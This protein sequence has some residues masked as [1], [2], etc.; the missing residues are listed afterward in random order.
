LTWTSSLG[1]Q[2]KALSG[3]KKRIGI[4]AGQY[5]DSET[6]LHYNYH[7]YYDPNTGRYLTPDPIGLAGG[8]NLFSYSS[9][10]PAN[11]NDPY[12]LRPL[13]SKEINALKKYFG[14]S[15]KTDKIDLEI[16]S[17]GGAWSPYGNQISLPE[18]FFKNNDECQELELTDPDIFSIF[19]HEAFHV[20]Q[21]QHGMNVTSEAFFLHMVRILSLGNYDPYEYD[22]SITTPVDLLNEFRSSNVEAQAQIYQDYVW[23]DQQNL[24]SGYRRFSTSKFS[25]VFNYVY[26]P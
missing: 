3:A 15:L 5:Y 24:R 12:G 18:D 2:K 25:D 13:K 7:R 1:G 11:W 26:R 21:R 8:L 20:W 14:S 16:S 23:R 6:R 10:N 17:H 9:N 19:I 4:Y 22:T